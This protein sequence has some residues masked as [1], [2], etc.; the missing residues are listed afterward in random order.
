[1]KVTLNLY[2]DIN[3]AVASFDY[4]QHDQLSRPLFVRLDGS[5]IGSASRK[6]CMFRLLPLFLKDV[7]CKNTVWN[8]YCL[9][10]EIRCIVLHRLCTPAVH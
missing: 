4:S 1:M 7:P 9:L 3:K 8:L 6:W 5:I 10:Q 2:N